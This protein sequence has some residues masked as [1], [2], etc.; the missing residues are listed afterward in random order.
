MA[1]DQQ[2]E[3]M[4]VRL[5]AAQEQVAD[6]SAGLDRVR[7]EASQAVFELKQKVTSLESR[8]S[9]EKEF[10]LV[11]RKEFSGDK[12]SGDKKENFKT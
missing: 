2:L 3:A 4:N 7:S 8:N 1:A 9:N 5:Q 10:T 6:L 12:F 11:N